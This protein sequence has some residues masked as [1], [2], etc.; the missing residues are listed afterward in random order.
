MI[1]LL[2]WSK[3]LR[4]ASRGVSTFSNYAKAVVLFVTQNVHM[5]RYPDSGGRAQQPPEFRILYISSKIPSSA[6]SHPN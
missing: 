5:C 4:W 1:A 3:I 6:G 2:S